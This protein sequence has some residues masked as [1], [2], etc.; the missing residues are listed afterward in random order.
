MLGCTSMGSKNTQFKFEKKTSS[1]PSTIV[2]L[3]RS[4]SIM[5]TFSQAGVMI[6]GA[7]AFDL[8]NNE[9][10]LIN[11]PRG[12][13]TFKFVLPN[14]RSFDLVIPNSNQEQ[15]VMFDITLDGFYV[16]MTTHKWQARLV[17]K[18]VFNKECTASKVVDVKHNS[19]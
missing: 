16:V 7:P 17:N 15:Y 18:D 14:D 2:S 3:C 11:L 8:G 9:R 13:Q 5:A 10:Y 19:L 12:N 6:N 4:S 1:T